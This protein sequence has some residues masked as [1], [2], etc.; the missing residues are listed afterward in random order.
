MS[1]STLNDF[2]T[3]N[4]LG[5]GSYGIVYKVFLFFIYKFIIKI[6]PKKD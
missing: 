6:G 3:L 1:V 4:E 2:I 5:R